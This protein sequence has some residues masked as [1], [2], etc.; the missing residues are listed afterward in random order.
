[1]AVG[2]L[3]LRG[4]GMLETGLPTGVV[5]LI[6]GNWLAGTL[7][8]ADPSS[9]LPVMGPVLLQ[10]PGWA[11]CSLAVARRAVTPSPWP[12]ASTVYR[13]TIDCPPDSL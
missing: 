7:T 3:A 12:S 6:G 9:R 8:S 10:M 1:M 5:W 4:M 13:P 2:L 11:S